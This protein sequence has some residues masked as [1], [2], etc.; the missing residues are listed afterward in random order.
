[1]ENKKRDIQEK[2]TLRQKLMIDKQNEM[3]RQMSRAD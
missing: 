3:I 1:M 2:M